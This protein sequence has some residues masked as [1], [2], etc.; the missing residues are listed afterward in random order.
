MTQPVHETFPSGLEV[1]VLPLPDRHVVSFQICVL[2][3]ACNEPEDKLGL[4]RLLGETLD[5][6]TARRGGRE[7][8]DAFD[9]LGA[10]H[11]I[12]TGRETITL[13]CTVLPEHFE[14][15]VA[16]HAEMLREPAFPEDALNVNKELA[17]TQRRALEDSPRALTN[18]LIDPAAFGTV[19][20]RHPLGEMET[21]ARVTRDDLVAFWQRFFRPGR[22]LA[23]AAGAVEPADVLRIFTEHLDGSTDGQREGREPFPAVFSARREHHDKPLEQEQ[24]SLCWPGVDVTDP[25]YPVQR[26]TLGLLSGGMSGRLFTEV[27]E[28]Q[29]LVYWV[30][31]WQK[32]PRGCGRIFLGASTTPERCDRT[33]ATLL[34]EVE[35]L[36]EDVTQDELERATTGIVA[37]YQTTGDGTSDRC[38]ELVNDLFFHGRPVPIEEK[39]EKVRSVG[40][41]DVRRYLEAHPRDR[42]CVL[43]LGPRAL[44]DTPDTGEEAPPS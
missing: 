33:Y 3:G 32:T 6:G 34:R 18:K 26:V 44:S 41:A 21:L 16:L 10:S 11:Q 17:C 39:I 9:T 13:A 36:A 12:G 38:E 28:K 15:A 1:G 5:K 31:A 20:G 24:I 4:A 14:R 27:R 25:E 8:L 37:S 42:L 35:R 40:T 7:L 22:M 23:V 43:T 19:L 30:G 29:G 2:A